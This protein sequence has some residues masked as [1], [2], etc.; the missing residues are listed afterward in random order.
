MNK[1]LKNLQVL[2]ILV[3]RDYALQYAGS[4]L[5]ILWMLIQSLS[6]IG[7]Y[8]FVFFI[9]NKASNLPNSK[10]DYSSYIFSGLLFWIPLQEMLIRG[11][12]ILTDNRQLIKRSSL[13]ANLFLWIPFLQMLIHS[14]VISVPVFS[15]LFWSGNL[16]YRFF[17]FAYLIIFIAGLYLMLILEYLA[18]VN[19]LLKDISPIMRLFSQ[20][21]FWTLPILYFPS[22][23]LR[24]VN[25]YN[26]FIILLDV[27]RFIVLQNYSLQFPVYIF[28]FPLSFFILIFLLTR[29]KLD[30]VVMDHL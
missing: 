18:R 3:K 16:D 24:E 1:A 2:W 12:T 20:I 19:I 28:A 25:L 6:L 11:V 30:E 5:G 17:Y 8:T 9:L 22:G 27:F 21:I 26:P 7:I 15:V 29:F 4:L 13:G 10:L 23:I 14:F